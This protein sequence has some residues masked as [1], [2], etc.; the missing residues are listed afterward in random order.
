MSGRVDFI[1]SMGNAAKNKENEKPANDDATKAK[2]KEPEVKKKAAEKD[3][4]QVETSPQSRLAALRPRRRLIFPF[5]FMLGC[6]WIATMHEPCKGQ[7]KQDCGWSG[8][9][10]MTCRTYACFLK[11]GGERTS[12]T[13]KVKKEKDAKFGITISGV[14]MTKTSGV[15]YIKSIDDGA[16]R[17]YN[18]A[19]PEDSDDRFRVGDLVSKIDADKG[20]KMKKVLQNQDAKTFSFDVKRS[21]LPSYLLWTLN[22]ESLA[23]VDQFVTAPLAQRWSKTMSYIGGAGLASWLISGYPLTSLPMYFT[24]SAAVS[25]RINGCCFNAQSKPGTPQCFKPRAAEVETLIPQVYN[26]TVELINKIQKKPEKYFGFLTSWQDDF[27]WL[28]AKK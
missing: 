15:L 28:F 25:F 24:I 21:V 10:A 26:S 14:G 3:K 9:T 16:V 11:D 13:M 2:T 17:A 6:G 19:L 22:F 12:K 1:K 8:I 27:K 7:K 18:D 5:L 23:F 4:Q 20:N